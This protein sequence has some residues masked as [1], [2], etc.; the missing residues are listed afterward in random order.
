MAVTGFWPICGNLKDTLNYAD[1][2]NKTT[3]REYLDEDLYA[4]LRYAKNDN[5]TDREIFVG[6]INCSRQ[7]AYAEMVAVQRRFGMKGKVVGYH[8]IQSF[9]EGEVTPELAF[10]IG[11]ETA[12]RMWGDKYQVLVTVH[13]NTDNLHCHFVVNPCSF[14]DGQKF[15]NKIG[16][17]KELRKISDEICREYGL[18]V[19]EDSEFYSKDKKTEYWAKKSGQ[20]TH[21]EQLR[22]DIEYCLRV[23]YNFDGFE[24]QLHGLGYKIDPVRFSVRAKGWERSV[25]LES[26]GYSRE[27]I[28]N[29][30]EE[31]LDSPD[32]LYMWN[33]HLPYKPKCFPLEN[34]IRKLEFSVEHS[35]D[36]A[37]V[38]VDTMFLILLTLFEIVRQSSD[39][40][41]LSPDLRHE[42]QNFERFRED[43]HFLREEGIHTLT[44]LGG[45]IEETK[46]KISELEHLR[47]KADNKRRRAAPE[48]KQKYKDERAAIT[49]QI[50][51]LREKLKKAEQILENSPHLYELLQQEH[52]L[53]KEAYQK[54]RQRSR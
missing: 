22:E 11:K 4:A 36:T 44:E 28:F 7:N 15:K 43:Y 46:T 54:Y 20:K 17:H 9:D 1:N 40:M 51:P 50:D 35:Y 25:R 2:P 23:S 49:R 13:L 45:N 34:E 33:T 39:I 53:E 32:C 29:L 10:E 3:A 5:K 8:G 41:L 18:S 38:L 16:D 21:R 48:K 37:I 6:G 52:R 14:V 19:L 24:S 30:L 12:R 47:D 31:H 42:V 26:I 27:R